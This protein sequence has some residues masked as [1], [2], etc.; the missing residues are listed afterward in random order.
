MYVTSQGQLV[1]LADAAA[2]EGAFALD[3]EF[4]PERTYFPRL[5]LVQIAVGD[6]QV[7][8]D[9]L[10][11]LDL[12]P[13]EQLVADPDVQVVVHAGYQ[14]MAII[15]HR[16]GQVP[17]NV[18]DT[19]LAAAF[20]GMGHQISY[21][22][23]VWDLTGV[24]LTRDA[25]FTDWM[26]RPLS[27]EQEAYALDDVRH[28]LQVRDAL[29]A[30]L[31]DLGR[32]GWARGEM[33]EVYG[34]RS[35]YEPDAWSAHRKVKRSG[36][37]KGR[38][39][40]VLVE[41]AAWRE[42]EAIKRDVPRK[43]VLTDEVIVEIARSIPAG[44]D[45]LSRVHGLGKRDRSKHGRAILAAVRAGLSR[46]ARGVA[47]GGGRSTDMTDPAAIQLLLM[48]LRSICEREGLAQALVGTRADVEE[49]AGHLAAGGS[50]EGPPR[51]LSGWRA[52][53]VGDLLVSVM[54]GRVGVTWDAE[55]ETVRL[56]RR[57]GE[58]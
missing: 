14:D 11:A 7:L 13:L 58:G 24:G 4:I 10:G 38:G 21:A 15:Y 8:V 36:A 34:S 49:L 16:T 54:E 6:A 42:R 30:R 29:E 31:G 2:R 27:S 3:L 12:E 44:A 33:D 51:L 28:L 9:P 25:S 52:K 26:R 39:L 22:Q 45:D 48:A 53:V 57:D 50:G 1:A 19:Q 46:A 47:G 23:A 37:V 35:F 55:A 5:A 56:I 41:I 18:F 43:K 32:L 40:G 20:A 17:T